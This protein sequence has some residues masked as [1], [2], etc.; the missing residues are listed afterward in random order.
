MALFTFER[1]LSIVEIIC[2]ILLS[3]IDKLKDKEKDTEK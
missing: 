1:L 2:N 3:A